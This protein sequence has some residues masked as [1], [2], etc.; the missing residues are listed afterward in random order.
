M[1]KYKIKVVETLEKIV[2]IEADTEKEALEE[3][4]DKYSE[5]EIILYPEDHVNTEFYV[6]EVTK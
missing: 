4:L 6:V 1:K 3:A 2:E 5:E